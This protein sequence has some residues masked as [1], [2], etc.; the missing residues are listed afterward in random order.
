[1]AGVAPASSTS[2][3]K[4][5]SEPPSRP[6]ST[7]RGPH[8]PKAVGCPPDEPTVSDTLPATGGKCEIPDLSC[9]YGPNPDC[10]RLYQ[11]VDGAWWRYYDH[12][13]TAMQKRCAS[14]SSCP[15][16]ITSLEGAS[17]AGPR[18]CAYPTG[19]VC[20]CIDTANCGQ[21]PQFSGP[22]VW[23]WACNPP[24]E[25]FSAVSQLCPRRGSEVVYRSRRIVG[26]ACADPGLS[27]LLDWSSCKHVGARV[28]CQDGVWVQP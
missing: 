22:P 8:T 2:V 17:C 12:D 14:T 20:R 9:G 1:V 19:H 28:V 11:C 5:P 23:A 4:R 3:A 25:D 16:S 13:W 18:E 24:I 6:S 26:N 10:M 21:N 27:C 7:P 15:A